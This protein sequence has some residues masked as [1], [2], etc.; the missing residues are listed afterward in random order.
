MHWKNIYRGFMMGAIDVVPGVSGGTIALVLGIYD[1]L[2]LSINGLFSK[3][4]RKH[5]SFLI[6]LGIGIVSAVWLLSGL[7][8]W[9][10][11]HH[12]KPTQFAFLGLIL[13]VLPYLLKRSGASENFRV[14]HYLM[15]LIG[16]VIAGSLAF[17]HGNEAFVIVDIHLREYVFLFFA[18]FLGSTAMILPGISGSLVLLIIG[19]YGTVINAVSQLKFD[20]LIVV[21][22]GIGVGI[23]VMSK[24]IKYFLTH[25]AYA[26]YAVVIG[27][28]IG[29]I[30]VIFP[31]WPQTTFELITSAVAF[32]TGLAVAYLLALRQ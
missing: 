32:F 21:A 1:Q 8:E 2:I 6:P 25:Y 23:I 10:F 22:A 4:W 13:G 16:V 31:G 11:E 12:P 30:F 17:L 9:L 29:S 20:I 19:A 5:L 28:V 24:I 27:L 3:D 14:T 18:G 26:T 15:L 7:L